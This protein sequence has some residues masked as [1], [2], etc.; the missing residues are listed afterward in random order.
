MRL[1]R[2][3]A[4]TALVAGAPLLPVAQLAVARADAPPPG[5]VPGK[6]KLVHAGPLPGLVKVGPI[7]GG[8]AAY[9]GVA[10]PGQ[11]IEVELGSGLEV[12]ASGVRGR[13][14]GGGWPHAGERVGPIVVV[15]GQ[16]ANGNPGREGNSNGNP[17][18]SNGNPGREGNNVGNPPASN[19]PGGNPPQS[20]NGTSSSSN[21]GREGNSNG[22]PGNS[23]GN[24]GS[25]NGNPGREG[26]NVGNPPA[27][28]GPGGNPP[29]S[30]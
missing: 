25:S 24:P 18:S 12:E 6:V 21:P 4:A 13:I 11:V 2:L 1:I 5:L 8:P 19:G 29:R 14:G 9:E 23:N 3:V 10:V 26:N 7:G 30:A 28:N 15:T 17:G 27:S 16:A 20:V 22:N